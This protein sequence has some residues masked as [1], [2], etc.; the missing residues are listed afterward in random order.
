MWTAA[1]AAPDW[2]TGLPRLV[3]K[4]GAHRT[5][6]P[7]EPGRACRAR[8]V[9]RPSGPSVVRPSHSG[10]PEI[11]GGLPLRIVS[12][13]SRTTPIVP[14]TLAAQSSAGSGCAVTRIAPASSIRS[15]AIA[16]TDNRSVVSATLRASPTGVNRATSRRSIAR[17]SARCS[18]SWS[19]DPRRIFQVDAVL[20]EQRRD[21]PH[22]VVGHSGRVHDLRPAPRRLGRGTA[23]VAHDR[24]LPA[25]GGFQALDRAQRYPQ[26]ALST[27]TLRRRGP[28]R[29]KPHTTS[30]HTLCTT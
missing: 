26:P 11:P 4:R 2:T 17:S 21:L 5:S 6:G 27:P 20:G 18:L 15:D 25:N 28:P 3:I 14:A 19:G 23:Y 13:Q 1:R 29:Q 7:C 9:Q 8:R 10:H 24:I 16:S 12:S 22:Q 30:L